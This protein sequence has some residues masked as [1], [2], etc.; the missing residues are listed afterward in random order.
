MD[1]HLSLKRGSGGRAPLSGGQACAAG[2]AEP[3]SDRFQLFL[4]MLNY[5]HSQ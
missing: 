5:R 3:P 2:G 1:S 4:T